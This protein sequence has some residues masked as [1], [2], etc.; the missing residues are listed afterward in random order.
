MNPQNFIFGK[1]CFGFN[2]CVDS[3]EHAHNF[4]QDAEIPK[5]LNCSHHLSAVTEAVLISS[6]KSATG[7]SAGG[8]IYLLICGPQWVLQVGVSVVVTLCILCGPWY[9]WW[10]RYHAI[11]ESFLHLLNHCLATILLQLC[12]ISHVNV[13][14]V[15]KS[16]MS[17]FSCS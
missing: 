12:L 14:T 11:S 10:R 8:S 17:R 15:F 5:L 3:H 2:Q 1:N 7:T 4:L 16:A 6:L 13:S 9:Y